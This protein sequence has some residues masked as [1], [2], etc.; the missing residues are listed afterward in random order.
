M[1]MKGTSSLGSDFRTIYS[2]LNLK[3]C[4]IVFGI[5]T[6]QL[7]SGPTKGMEE[8]QQFSISFGLGVGKVKLGSKVNEILALLANDFPRTDY[9][10]IAS[11][12]REEIH[13]CIPQ[14]GI[15]CRFLPKSQSLYLIDITDV[16]S[17]PYSLNGA[18]IFQKSHKTTFKSLQKVL[19]PSFPG[20]STICG[21]IQSILLLLLV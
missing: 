16:Q 21:L 2:F 6:H 18:L 9:D 14:W 5:P 15:R 12:A 4:P 20:I 1:S 10:V 7:I 3:E 17:C 8:P 19:G 11:S 13:I